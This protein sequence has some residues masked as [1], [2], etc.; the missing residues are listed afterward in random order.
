M[1]AQQTNS[2]MVWTR[3]EGKKYNPKKMLL[4]EGFFWGYVH[5]F[6]LEG[7]K[8][9]LETMSQQQKEDYKN[10]FAIQILNGIPLPVRDGLPSYVF[11]L[12]VKKARYRNKKRIDRLKFDVKKGMVWYGTWT[13][14]EVTDDSSV[15]I[16]LNQLK[17]QVKFNSK[18]IRRNTK[19]ISQLEKLK[20]EAM[21]FILGRRR[22]PV[23]RRS[24]S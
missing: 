23:T 17:E 3:L 2:T 7:W 15:L 22:L 16:K 14:V 13:N 1:S 18:H 4:Q 21:A 11:E 5:R 10:I 9:E 24:M 12:N 8:E 19:R 20:E 6:G